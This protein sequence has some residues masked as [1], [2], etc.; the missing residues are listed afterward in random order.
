MGL[1]LTNCRTLGAAMT[2]RD[3]AEQTAQEMADALGEAWAPDPQQLVGGG[4]HAVAQCGGMRVATW[5]RPD[6]EVRYTAAMQRFPT[7]VIGT[8]SATPLEAV[9][10]LVA[11][12]QTA[13]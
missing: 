9:A 8:G 10:A 13:Q 5:I 2:S 3:Q 12:A 4:W 6:G 1:Q 11:G 7:R